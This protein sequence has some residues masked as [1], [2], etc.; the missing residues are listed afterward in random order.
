MTTIYA[1]RINNEIQKQTFEK[2]LS[3]LPQ[4]KQDRIRKFRKFEDAR[5]ALVAHIL[6]RSIIIKKLGMDNNS[7]CFD[8]GKNGKPFLKGVENF[9]FNLSHSGYWVVCA[10]SSNPVGI[11]VEEIRE[12]DLGIA[13]RFFAKEE[14]E[15]LTNVYGEERY[16]LFFDLW[17]LKESYIKLDGRGLAIP[18]DSFS[19]NIKEEEIIFKT[20]NEIVNCFFKQY[21]IDKDFSLAVC[22][23]SYNFPDSLMFVNEESLYNE[24]LDCIK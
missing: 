12:I 13:E 11:D 8:N 4:D 7:I 9:H 16:K 6:I 20:K 23:T 17:T 18:L 5:R 2:T 19:F 3:L 1:V 22:S 21:N 10:V 14:T 24:F 15:Q